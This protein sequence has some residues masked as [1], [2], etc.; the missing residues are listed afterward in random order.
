MPAIAQPPCFDHRQGVGGLL[1]D[2]LGL[3]LQRTAVLA[4]PL[5]KPRHHR[6]IQ[7]ANQNLRHDILNVDLAANETLS[8]AAFPRQSRPAGAGTKAVTTAVAV[9]DCTSYEGWESGESA[10]GGTMVTLPV[11][12]FSILV[13]RFLV[14]GLTADAING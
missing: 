14:R 1:E 13:R 5:L 6:G 3:A 4:R 9:V 7:V 2:G 10:A 11:L 8:R 12:F